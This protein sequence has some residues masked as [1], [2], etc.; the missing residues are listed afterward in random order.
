MRL[1]WEG[2]GCRFEGKGRSSGGCTA[3][4]YNELIELM[5]ELML[6]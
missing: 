4:R 5:H 1:L 6:C 2:V 3:G